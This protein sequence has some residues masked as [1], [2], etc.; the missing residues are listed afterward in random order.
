M[1]ASDAASLFRFVFVGD[2]V[3]VGVGVGVGEFVG[4]FVGCVVGCCVGDFSGVGDFT[5]AL[6]L[7]SGCVTFLHLGPFHFKGDNCL[8]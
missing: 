3:G 5:A 2:V 8:H 6:G 4:D 1:V 7:G